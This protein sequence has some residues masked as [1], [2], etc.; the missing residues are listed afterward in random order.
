MAYNPSPSPLHNI[1]PFTMST[2]LMAN[3]VLTFTAFTQRLLQPPTYMS[4]QRILTSTNPKALANPHVNQPRPSLHSGSEQFSETLLTSTSSFYPPLPPSALYGP[5]QNE[6]SPSSPYVLM[7][8]QASVFHFYTPPGHHPIQ[9]HHSPLRNTTS[10]VVNEPQGR[11]NKRRG[12]GGTRGGR[13]KRRKITSAEA[14]QPV[15]APT[16]GVGPIG[17]EL[18]QDSCIDESS[19]TNPVAQSVPPLHSYTNSEAFSQQD[20]AKSAATDVWYFMR[21]LDTDKEPSVWPTNKPRLRSRPNT[22]YVGC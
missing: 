8:A 16:C 20:G 9:Q 10:F 17:T 15:A 6:G 2:I 13:G 5:P 18:H 12:G 14:V 1:Q 3:S 21:A 7:G 4:S 11:S 22:K 19:I